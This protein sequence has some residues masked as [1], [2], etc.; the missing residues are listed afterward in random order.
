MKKLLCI[1][2]FSI[3]IMANATV[4]K[5]IVVNNSKEVKVEK[6]TFEKTGYNTLTSIMF[7]G[8]ASDGNQIYDIAISEGATHREARAIRRAW[9]RKCRAGFWQ[10]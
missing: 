9:V 4:K 7:F 5:E 10:F 2:L 3:A 1:A 8:C 6:V